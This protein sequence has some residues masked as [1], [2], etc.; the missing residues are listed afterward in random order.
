MEV[1]DFGFCLRLNTFASKISSS[2]L[3]PL[4]ADGAGAVNLD[5]RNQ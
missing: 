4:G 5:I 3:L 2:L 1:F